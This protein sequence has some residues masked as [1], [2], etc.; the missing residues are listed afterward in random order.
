MKRFSSA[1]FSKFL[2]L[3]VGQNSEKFP[4]IPVVCVCV[5]LQSP[6]KSHAT[7]LNMTLLLAKWILWTTEP[8]YILNAKEI[9]KNTKYSRNVK[10]LKTRENEKRCSIGKCT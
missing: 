2:K 10:I 8:F 5:R 4:Q 6:S 3:I 7:S 9:P 1:H